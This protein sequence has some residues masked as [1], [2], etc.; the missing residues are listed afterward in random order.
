MTPIA[1][2]CTLQSRAPKGQ[3]VQPGEHKRTDR[4]TDR[5]TD[6]QTLPIL[7]SPFF[8]K[9][10]WSIISLTW[11]KP[12]NST[13]EL[14][15][16]RHDLCSEVSSILNIGV[17]PVAPDLDA[18]GIGIISLY[19]TFSSAGCRMFLNKQKVW[20]CEAPLGWQKLICNA[21]GINMRPLS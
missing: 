11:T 19:S 3:A 18:S 5:Q 14:F 13:S 4:R 12:S 8:A 20:K 9:A 21:L 16:V 2:C 7:L 1:L 17:S 10:T 15:C 6:K